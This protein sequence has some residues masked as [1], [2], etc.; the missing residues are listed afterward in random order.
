MTGM[1]RRD[2]LKR[3]RSAG[4]AAGLAPPLWGTRIFRDTENQCL[5]HWRLDGLLKNHARHYTL[6]LRSKRRNLCAFHVSSA[7]LS[8][9]AL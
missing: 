5:R 4:L 9:S 6:R 3:S 7:V 1:T 8:C 2:F